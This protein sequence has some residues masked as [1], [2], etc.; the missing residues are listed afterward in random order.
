MNELTSK[1]ELIEKVVEYADKVFFYCIKR[2]N[3]RADAEDL[4]QT[5]LLEIIQNINKGARIDNMDYYIWGVCKNQYNMYLRRIIKNRETIEYVE[6]II[7]LDKSISPLDE[8]MMDEKI[9][10]MNQA[11]KLLSKDYAEILYAYYV[12]DKTLKFISKE[13]NIPLGT[14]KKRLF[15]I[16]KKLKEYLDMEKLNGKKA[17]VPKNFVGIMTYEGILDFDPNKETSPL[18]IKNLLYHSY[19]NPCTIE[20]Y[21]LELGISIPYIE[22][23]IEQLLEKEFLIKLDNR[24]YLT[25]I[26]FVDKI[27]KRKINDLVRNNIYI[28]Q[29]RVIDFCKKNLDYYRSLLENEINDD[30]LLMWS[31][32]YRVEVILTKNKLYQKTKKCKNGSWNYCMEEITNNNEC[33]KYDEY[34]I[35]Y[36][37]SSVDD[38]NVSL[39]AWPSAV[40]NPSFKVG[41]RTS[42]KNAANASENYLLFARL[43]EKPSR[44]NDLDKDTKIL[45]KDYIDKNYLKIKD[46]IIEVVPPV[47]FESNLLKLDDLIENDYTLQKALNEYSAIVYKEVEKLFPSYLRDQLPFIV[48]AFTVAERSLIINYA[49]NMGLL[50]LDENQKHFVYNMMIILK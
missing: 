29:N 33:D 13:L 23:Y 46:E 34:F 18:L 38:C 10:K 28:L 11:I 15:T 22:D 16:R 42:T 27:T 32:I 3:T 48:S 26:A 8:L 50:S 12:E 35:S 17:Y 39:A 36:N 21:S 14:V 5:I 44:Y 20:D 6:E 40:D 30:K 49:Y 4:S 43:L 24:K 7:E 45:V 19:D 1:N 2:C 9:R 31:L 25:N 47:I 41:Y 37:R